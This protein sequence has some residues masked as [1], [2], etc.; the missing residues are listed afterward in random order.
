MIWWPLPAT[1]VASPKSAPGVPPVSSCTGLPT[2]PIAGEISKSRLG[3]GG[4]LMSPLPTIRSPSDSSAALIGALNAPPF[5]MTRADD[6]EG[7]EK[8]GT[9]L[10]VATGE[11]QFPST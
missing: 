3:I 2:K 10:G 7:P 4:L 1:A 6:A 9:G 5:A 8:V 11:G